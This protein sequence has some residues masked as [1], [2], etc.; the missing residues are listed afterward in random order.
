MTILSTVVG[1][2]AYFCTV[3]VGVSHEAFQVMFRF[4]FV[5][6]RRSGAVA[7]VLG[8][9]SLALA[10]YMT[11]CGAGRPER[12][13][14][15]D[16]LQL[17]ATSD[18]GKVVPHPAGVPFTQ[19]EIDLGKML[20]F[21]TALS[22]NGKVSCATCHNPGLTYA[23]GLALSS[24][25][26]TGKQ[27][28]RTAPVII[29]MA[30]ADSLFWDGRASSLEHQ[31]MG[32]LTARD[33]MG[34]DSTEIVTKAVAAHP[35]LVDYMWR[36]YGDDKVT[37]AR[38]VR[39]IAQYERSLVSRNSLYD[40]YRERK[41]G[42]RI[43]PKDMANGF[44]VFNINC[45]S[46]HSGDN[47]TDGRFHNIGLDAWPDPASGVPT[48]ARFRVTGLTKDI[49]KYKTP[50]L[51]NVAT[52]APYMHDGR[53][54]TL[55]EVVDFYTGKIVHTPNLAPQ[56]LDANGKP[57]LKINAQDK[58]DLIVFLK[59]LTDDEFLKNHRDDFQEAQQLMK[60]GT[61]QASMLK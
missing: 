58:A 32:P 17:Q 5:R 40:R 44:M 59:S 1:L 48:L 56:M 51:R 7:L 53:F 52:T 37:N 54:K 9:G 36:I 38:I 46:C 28:P 22:K 20:F 25:G 14:A 23:D 43:M 31:A 18:G 24:N 13:T 2:A 19:T 26:V 57:G 45:G 55:E 29:N 49:G 10:S 16:T 35:N 3:M 30:W 41:P 39:A 50:G 33:E 15:A 8:V 6:R 60:A 12:L 27:L 4:E 21:S 61:Q 11:G 34:L 42:H 47:F